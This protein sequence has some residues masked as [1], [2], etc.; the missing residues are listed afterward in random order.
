MIS[1]D[2]IMKFTSVTSALQMLNKKSI[3]KIL[4][5][6]CKHSVFWNLYAYTLTNERNWFSMKK[7][8]KNSEKTTIFKVKAKDKILLCLL[9]IFF[10][11]E[12]K[13]E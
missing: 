6:S 1:F 3:T 9:N 2:I 5:F 4:D 7:D 11:E 13:K 8:E 10:I 12:Q